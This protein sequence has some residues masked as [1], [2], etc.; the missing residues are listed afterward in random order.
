M[1]SGVLLV[2]LLVSWCDERLVRACVRLAANQVRV[3]EE[4]RR[5]AE[6]PLRVSTA[7]APLP[8]LR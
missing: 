1:F 4:L 6:I 2:L 5:F 8:A 3:P 7:A